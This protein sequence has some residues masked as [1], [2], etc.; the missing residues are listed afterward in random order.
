MRRMKHSRQLTAALV[1]ALHAA[2]AQAQRRSKEPEDLKGSKAS[3]EK[4]YTFAVSH[5][6]PFY[7]TQFALDSAIAQKK[8]V[9]LAG[10]STY[11][12]TRGVGF[13]YAT[14]EAKQ[15]ILAF[16]PQYLQA[17][18]APLTV[19]SAA[20]PMNKQPHNANPHSVHPA[21]IAVDIRRPFPGP[22]LDWT[23]ATLSKFE[24]KGMI[25]VTEEHHPVHI[26]IAVLT[27]PG[28]KVVLPN[29]VTVVAQRAPVIPLKVTSAGEVAL[30]G[31]RTYIVHQGD[32]LWDIANKT[33]VTVA[34][35]TKANGAG[36]SHALK[37]GT[38]LIVPDLT[39]H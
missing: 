38:T 16:A 22:C 36:V 31:K 6:L 25:E 34:A 7:P 24:E 32:T 28:R 15:F 21:A 35:L 23:R 13:S 2:S 39:A 5:H 19:T 18:G 26:H 4:M 3:V 17:C 12:M 1:I 9:E 20:R 27:E 8:L 33:G 14:R 29:M 11:E 10:D 30:Q 37:P